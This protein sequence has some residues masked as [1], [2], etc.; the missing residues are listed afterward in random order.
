MIV[1]SYKCGRSKSEPDKSARQERHKDILLSN[2]ASFAPDLS[3]AEYCKPHQALLF[4]PLAALTKHCPWNHQQVPATPGAFASVAPPLR[5]VP[6][7]QMHRTWY[8][9]GPCNV[10]DAND[11]HNDIQ[12]SCSKKRGST[13]QLMHIVAFNSFNWLTCRRSTFEAWAC[14]FSRTPPVLSSFPRHVMNLPGI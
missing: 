6:R 13:Q 2:T 4:L 1:I 8:D 3:S 12:W 14:D 5:G 10:Q 11:I 9:S 7:H